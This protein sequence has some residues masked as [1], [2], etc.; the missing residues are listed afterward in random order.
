MRRACQ[1][2]PSD[3][4]RT[5]LERWSRGRSTQVRLATRARVVLTAP[6]GKE[7]KDLPTELNISRGAVASWRDC[8]AEASLAGISR[9][10]PRDERPPKGRG[11]SS[12][13]SSR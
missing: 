6:G 5:T 13:R 2:T 8:F 11:A 7:N 9:D 12:A 1:I 3:E 4:D 10:A